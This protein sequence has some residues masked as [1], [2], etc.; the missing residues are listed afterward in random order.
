MATEFNSGG[1][2]EKDEVTRGAMNPPAR[3]GDVRHWST[4]T[5]L[6]MLAIVVV[7]G[8]IFSVRDATTTASDA[9][10][11]VTTGIS[12]DPTPSNP[13]AARSPQGQGERNSTR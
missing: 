1:P 8:L 12:A 9:T 6:A 2:L 5:I 3:V 7:I 4:I 13:P 10:P 11:G